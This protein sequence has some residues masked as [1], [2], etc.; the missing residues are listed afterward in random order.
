MTEHLWDLGQ[1]FPWHHPRNR[2]AASY[3]A[4]D[5]EALFGQ[6]SSRYFNSVKRAQIQTT[7]DLES[8][9]PDS[10]N[11]I[12]SEDSLASFEDDFDVEVEDEDDKD[13]RDLYASHCESTEDIM[14]YAE[15]PLADEEWLKKYEAANKENKRLEQELQARLDGAVQVETWWV[16]ENHFAGVLSTVNKLPCFFRQKA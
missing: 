5:Q 2:F 12:V 11:I 13:E 3:K 7:W 4:Y 10:E 9:D 8:S 15:E 14:A 6:V 1:A 16:S